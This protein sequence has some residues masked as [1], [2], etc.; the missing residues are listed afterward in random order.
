MCMS[1]NSNQGGQAF[2]G[3]ATETNGALVSVRDLLIYKL[4]V[5]IAAAYTA[6]AVDGELRVNLDFLDNSTEWVERAVLGRCCGDITDE[7]E[8][9][10]G[11]AFEAELVVDGAEIDMNDPEIAAMYA[12]MVE[13]EDDPS[14]DEEMDYLAFVGEMAGFILL[15]EHVEAALGKQFDFL[16]DIDAQSV[17]AENE[18]GVLERFNALVDRLEAE[19]GCKAVYVERDVSAEQ[20]IRQQLEAFYTGDDKPEAGLAARVKGGMEYKM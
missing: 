15:R 18:E 9:L 6:I 4:Y 1:N 3:V 14:G 8:K 19:L 2:D 10:Y 17:S 12:G 11:A 5:P 13:L 16:T 7:F 20:A